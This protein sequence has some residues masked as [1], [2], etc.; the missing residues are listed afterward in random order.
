VALDVSLVFG[1]IVPSPQSI[2][3]S[4][5]ADIL[6]EKSD[7]LAILIVTENSGSIFVQ[8]IAALA[9]KPNNIVVNKTAQKRQILSILHPFLVDKSPVDDVSIEKNTYME[10]VIFYV[11]QIFIL[12]LM[13]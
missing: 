11:L 3:K 8:S 4:P 1:S 10:Q 2:Q 13:K 12:K 6:N 7:A 9:E 5:P